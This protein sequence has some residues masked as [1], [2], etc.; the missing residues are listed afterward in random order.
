GASRARPGLFREAH[1]GTIL[2]DEISEMDMSTQ[3]KLLR[4]LQERTV[5]PVGEDRDDSV[6]VRVL[7]T[8][9]KDLKAEVAAGRFREDLYYRLDVVE[10]RLPP[11]EERMD[12][13]PV[14]ITHF[15]DMYQ[16][17]FATG[18]LTLTAALREHLQAGPFPGNV[19]ELEH[20]VE[21]A[22]AL[23]T[24]GVAD[25]T[26]L[27]H[28][29]SEEADKASFGLK[30]RVDA[31]ERGILVHELAQCRGNRSEAARRLGIA[32]V[33]LLEKLKKYGITRDSE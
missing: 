9:N 28:P 22:V 12:D 18:P 29:R 23:S 2:L 20:R 17:R 14:L 6:D 24:G 16:N 4:V 25:A 5:R 3:G 7:A 11:L 26:W 1:G 31:Y 13:V 30:E 32:R 33:T 8:T 19:R 10:V 21:R 15:L 27:M